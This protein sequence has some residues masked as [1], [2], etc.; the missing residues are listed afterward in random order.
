MIFLLLPELENKR[1]S[2]Q[3]ELHSKEVYMKSHG[4]QNIVILIYNIL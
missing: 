3:I 2:L 1:W 4:R